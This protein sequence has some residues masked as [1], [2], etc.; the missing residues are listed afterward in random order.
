VLGRFWLPIALGV[1]LQFLCLPLAGQ[2]FGEPELVFQDGHQISVSC[3]AFSPDGRLVASGGTDRTLRL[4]DVG[5]GRLLRTLRGHLAPINALS[6]FPDGRFLISAGDDVNLRIWD[7]ASGRLVNTLA[8]HRRSVAALDFSPDGRRFATADEG[9]KIM[10]WDASSFGLLRVLEAD[11]HRVHSIDFSPDGRF[12]ASG[13]GEEVAKIWEV[14][15][16]ALVKTLDVDDV[17]VQSVAFSPTGKE[18]ATTSLGAKVEIWNPRS[19]AVLDRWQAHENYTKAA[20]YSPDG[21]FLATLGFLGI[22]ALKLWDRET[23]DLVKIIMSRGHFFSAIAFSPDGELLAT[24]GSDS[25]RPAVKIWELSSSKPLHTL[26]GEAL[27]IGDMVL[28]ADGGFLTA[29]TRGD[30]IA[31]WDRRAGTLVR[32]LGMPDH[33]VQVMAASP[34][35]KLLAAGGLDELIRLWDLTTGE[36]LHTLSGHEEDITALAFS[37]D[38]EILA[39][40]GGYRDELLRLWEVKTGKLLRGIETDGGWQLDLAFSPDGEILASSDLHEVRLWD[41]ATGALLETFQGY[42]HYSSIDA[43]AF[44]PDG[45]TLVA[46][47]GAGVVRRWQLHAPR[48]ISRGLEGHEGGVG[49]VAVSPDGRFLVS[50]S[51][52]ETVKL[53]DLSTRKVVH[54]FE[55]HQER[56]QEVALSADGETL[57]T[58]SWDDGILLWDVASRALLRTIE[59]AQSLSSLAFSPD[60]RRLVSGHLDY[61]AKVWDVA[62]GEILATL[63][64]HEESVMSVAFSPDG[65]LV[66]SGGEDGTARIWE[67]E[68]G[69]P[70]HVIRPLSGR[71]LEAV[72]FSPDGEL[73]ATGGALDAPI[74][75]WDVASGEFLES[76]EAEGVGTIYSL[77][78]SSDGTTLA[79]GGDERIDFWS[80]ATGELVHSFPDGF[81]LNVESLS[82]SADGTVIAGADGTTQKVRYWRLEPE[83]WSDGTDLHGPSEGITALA[84]SPDGQTLAAGDENGEIQLWG[85]AFWNRSRTIQAHGLEIEALAFADGGRTLVS[86]SQDASI[87]YWHRATG[88]LLAT[89]YTF[90]DDYL[91]F[92]PSGVYAASPGAEKS[93]SWRLAG[94]LHDHRRFRERFHRPDLVQRG[95]AGFPVAAPRDPRPS[96]VLSFQEGIPRELLSAPS[97]RLNGETVTV[98]GVEP[99]GDALR[100]LGSGD[101]LRQGMNWLETQ[102]RRLR[103]WWQEAK[104]LR[105]P[106][107]YETSYAILVA[108]DDYGRERD[109][110]RGPTRLDPLGD[111][112][113]RAEELKSALIAVGFPEANILT[114]YDRQATSGRIT[115]ELERFWE[116]EERSG[117]DRLFFYF[118][119]HGRGE[120]GN[121][122]LVTY[123][124][125]ADR[126]ARTSFL[127]SDVLHRHFRYAQVHHMLFALD[128]CSSGLAI[129]GLQTLDDLEE[130]R[131]RRFRRLANVLGDTEHV[132]RNLLV[133]GTR[134]EQAIYVNGGIFTRALTDGLR[135]RADW[136][137]DGVI[138]FEELA[139]HIKNSV[140][141]EALRTGLEQTPAYYSAEALGSGRMLFLI[142]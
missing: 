98:V 5:T 111:M 16:G 47:S 46:S 85:T 120:E 103:F 79:S 81:I 133:A 19:G 104:L 39:S 93:I 89:S 125:D 53:W 59:E 82:F 22:A 27:G 127:M 84:F 139:L 60:G 102:D 119:G 122:Y 25:K 118:G 70:L 20:V 65:A 34:D 3:V 92:T 11:R 110:D 57:A 80:T 49:A 95:L 40:S 52:D 18:L 107:P 8:G 41:V 48:W 129:P 91:T 64:G 30:S 135:S 10:I 77:A 32:K 29:A 97:L 87:R 44:S 13:G 72:A 90:A 141:A 116:G 12:L 66:A 26:R 9:G 140:R 94:E 88:D 96:T 99:S 1:F 7:P 61:D 45:K 71:T 130:D 86:A 33:G 113:K 128:A 138:Q 35:G 67:A 73:L 17:W 24:A 100:L 114:L 28:S 75:L 112:V 56:I 108:I 131:I 121:G 134:E 21:R 2:S 136:N 117:A 6:F 123:D 43:V 36:L 15:T 62:S 124:Y 115:R 51:S 50:G 105:M 74:Q 76:F 132:A 31:V 83:R 109:P 142:P 101:L 68:T 37:P 23:Q 58:G 126:P 63:E 4:W 14:E 38:G 106:E 54:S 137:R 42:G 55:G 69:E 78:F